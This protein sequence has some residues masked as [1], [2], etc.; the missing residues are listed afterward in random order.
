M[1]CS[2]CG[3]EIHGNIQK[4][5]NYREAERFLKEGNV[6]EFIGEIFCC[7]NCLCW[8]C[9][10]EKVISGENADEIPPEDEIQDIIAEFDKGMMR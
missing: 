9:E 1:L 5:R 8:F 6:V 3:E 4:A 10:K 7:L 2:N